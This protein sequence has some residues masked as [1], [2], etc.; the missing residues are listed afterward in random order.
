MDLT[1]GIFTVPRPGNYFFSFSGVS[2]QNTIHVGLY[3]NNNR[4]GSGYGTSSLQTFTVQ[5]AIHL[6]AGDKVWVQIEGSNTL[7][8]TDSRYTHFIG[9]L[10]QEDPYPFVSQPLNDDLE[11]NERVE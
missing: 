2:Y 9:F 7:Y 5:S 11:E 10:L 4:I 3:V 8:D 1:S 6:N